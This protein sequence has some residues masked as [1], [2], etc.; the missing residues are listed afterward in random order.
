MEVPL[1]VL[2]YLTRESGDSKRK[3]VRRAVSGCLNI[4]AG[5]A[6]IA[7]GGANISIPLI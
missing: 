2:L 6:G 1:G 4:K 5:G 3:A 7:K